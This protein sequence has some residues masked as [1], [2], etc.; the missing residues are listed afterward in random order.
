[1]NNIDVTNIYKKINLVNRYQKIC[2]KYNDFDNALEGNHYKKY[3]EII[4]DFGYKPKYFKKE[5]FFRIEEMEK[6]IVFGLQ[7]TLK[8]GM[9]EVMFDTKLNNLWF[10]PDGRIDFICEEIDSNFDR[11]QYNIPDYPSLEEL[12]IILKEIFKIYEDF[13]TEI[14]NTSN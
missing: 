4:E 13:K 8:N 5:S 2:E 11:E 12:K 1:M 3:T 14:V 6:N 9:V 7:L 10:V